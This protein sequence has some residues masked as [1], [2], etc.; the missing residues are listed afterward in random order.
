ML[1]QTVIAQIDALEAHVAESHAMWEQAKADGRVGENCTFTFPRCDF[2]RA[3]AFAEHLDG[4]ANEYRRY[5]LGRID[6]AM[7]CGPNDA[8]VE[9]VWSGDAPTHL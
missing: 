1:T 3:R 5:L 4:A 6:E 2:A 9:W 8:H 7:Y